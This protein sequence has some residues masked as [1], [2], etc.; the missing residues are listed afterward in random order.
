MSTRVPSSPSHQNVWCGNRLVVF[1]DS[2]WVTNRRIPPAAYSWGMLAGYPNTSGIQTSLQRRPNRLSNQRWPCTIC[3]ARLSPDGRF[4]SASTH[5]PPTGI[6]WPP[7]TLAAIRSN[8]SG[9]RCSI[10][11]YCCACEH[12]KRYS[13]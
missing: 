2:F 6:H 13:G 5:I 9:W 8:S 4:M 7:C 12:E 1:H 11:A 10:H 3:R